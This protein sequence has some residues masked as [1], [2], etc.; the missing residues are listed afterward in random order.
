MSQSMNHHTTP[1]TEKRHY[2]IDLLRVVAMYMVCMIHI[3]FFCKAHS[4]LIPGKEYFYYFGIWTESLGYIGVNLYAMITGYVCLQGKWKFNRYLRLWVEVCFYTLGL[5]LVGIILSYYHILPWEISFK[6]IIRIIVTLPFGSTYWY[7][8]SYTAV[9]LLIPFINKL[10]LQLEQKQYLYLL[11]IVLVLI[12]IANVLVGPTLYGSGY[13]ATWLAALYAVGGYIKRYPIRIS[14]A[15][16][17]P[18]AGLCTLQPVIC[19]L[20][21][22][23]AYLSYCSPIMV[24]YSVCMFL[25]FTQ[26]SVKSQIT[27]KLIAWA[28]PLSFG[29]YLI[30][31]HPW[32]WAMLNK[33]IGA[34]NIALDSPWWIALVGGGVLY[35]I[36]TF[37]DC[38][39]D[40]LF[41]LTKLPRGVDAIADYICRLVDYMWGRIMKIKEFKQSK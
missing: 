21:C 4:E 18:I 33:Y 12:P 17:L 22:L 23:P 1:T 41:R 40:C 20:L 36:C 29:V 19:R 38:L 25:I 14:F 7:F 30:H 15:I 6:R 39:R 31:V 3:N 13:N 37:I 28:A 2:G 10:L 32:S 34:I 16:L 9:F 26:I 24:L 35:L 8:S 27:R 11:S 5:L